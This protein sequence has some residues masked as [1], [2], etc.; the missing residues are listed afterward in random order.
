[1]AAN[2]RTLA[3]YVDY[4]K[5][6]DRVW[7]AAL[8]IKLERIGMPL[9]LLKVINSWLKDRKAYVVFGEKTSKILKINIGLPQGS[10]L[11]P[12][13]FIVFHCDLIN[14]IDAHSGHLF[15][16]D[17]SILISP[18]II[19]NLAPMIQYLEK[20][21]TRICILIHCRMEIQHSAS[22]SSPNNVLLNSEPTPGAQSLT[23]S[24][25]IPGSQSLTSSEQIPGVQCV[26]KS[27]DTSRGNLF[28][29]SKQIRSDQLLIDSHLV[30]RG[31]LFKK[32]EQIPGAQSLTKSEQIL[33][34]KPSNTS[35]SIYKAPSP[36]IGYLSSDFEPV[37][38]VILLE[39]PNNCLA[40]NIVPTFN[41]QIIPKID[42]SLTVY[43]FISPVGSSHITEDFSINDVKIATHV[44]STTK[45]D[46]KFIP[47]TYASSSTD[48]IVNQQFERLD[49]QVKVFRIN[50]VTCLALNK[51][52][53]FFI[54]IDV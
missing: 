32:S 2:L 38:A 51:N 21:G 9:D 33:G 17:V 25:Q 19:K 48:M 54:L 42:L 34:S 47:S 7:H 37:E 6:Y 53:L 14:C 13:L 11:S 3:I 30:P 41:E 31:E 12:Y 49:D 28:E 16:D 15:A 8:L 27:E 50:I 29:N 43:K 44:D 23:N 20:E 39:V 26:R 46:C 35:T 1:M 10:S 52:I 24:E 45:K 5:A 40:N 18:P 22:P 36:S 4:Q